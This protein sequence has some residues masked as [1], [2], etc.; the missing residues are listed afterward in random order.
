VRSLPREPLAPR[1]S[2]RLGGPARLLVE[3]H[4]SDELIAALREHHDQPLLLLGGGSNL[5]VS[6]D[7]FDGVVVA[8]RSRGVS[9]R[10][11]GAYVLVDAAAGEPWDALV[12]RCVHEGL[13]GI[14]CL[15][16]IPGQVGATPIQNVGAYGQEVSDT[17]HRVRVLDRLH[18]QTLDFSPE[19]CAFGYR[20]SLFK[21]RHPGRYAVLSVTFRLRPGPPAPPHYAELSAALAGQQ[22]SL[23]DLR[24]L[25]LSLRRR[26]GMVL[27]DQD[28]DTRSAGSFFTNP[29]LSPEA[30]ADLQRRVASLL[31][32]ETR[33]PSFDGGPDRT[34]V[35]AAW[36]IEQ[37]GFRRGLQLAGAAI[38]PRHALALINRGGS[39]AD[40]LALARSIQQGVLQTFGVLL[41][42]EPILV[43]FGG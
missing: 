41:E 6:D 12:E 36:L 33:I 8:V 9:F 3:A 40:V 29:L 20:D 32:P 13:A 30:W 22:P 38:S 5:L 31:G 26:K 16:G 2:F 39:A 14:E 19:D 34:K 17:I 7:G 24:E 42:P 25:V 35:A 21:S 43:G 11:Q 1:T 37:A 4:S 15:S 18:Q 10:K 27:D 28:P 23:P